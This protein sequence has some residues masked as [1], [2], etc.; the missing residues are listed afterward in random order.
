M[1][2]HAV[3]YVLPFA[4]FLVFLALDGKLGLAPAVEYNLRIVVLAAILWVFSRHVIDL[5]VR[6]V[7][8]SILL[9]VV[10]FAVWI[11]PDALIPGY[12]QHWLFQNSIVG[13]APTPTDGYASLP[14][15]AIIARFAR[16][17]LLVPIIEELFWR[18]WLMRWLIKPEF[19]KVPLGTYSAQAF[20]ITV[21][22][23]A[24]EHGSYWE[25]GALAGIA[26]N[27]W[28][29]RTRSLGDCILAHAVTNAVLSAYV[30]MT[31]N[32]QYW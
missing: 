26:Y 31:G 23:F 29:V 12:R 32:W 13:S 18:G 25:V 6:N 10:V 15:I 17:A 14:L 20:W 16:A 3:P 27:W 7:G 2:H 8:G 9:G 1:K 11:A 19:E 30:L 28:M 22:L 24:A 5:R 21:A 4:A